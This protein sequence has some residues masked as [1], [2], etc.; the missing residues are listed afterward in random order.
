MGVL[1]LTLLAFLLLCWR[2]RH[3]T[4]RTPAPTPAMEHA[5]ELAGRPVQ[6]SELPQDHRW[7]TAELEGS[8]QQQERHELYAK[9]ADDPRGS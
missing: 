4:N 8:T 2:R 7:Q 9:Q 5:H 3:Q 6:K 1:V